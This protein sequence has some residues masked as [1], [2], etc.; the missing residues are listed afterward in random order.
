MRGEVLLF[1]TLGRAC[2]ITLAW[3][4]RSCT[5]SGCRP[6]S[7]N[8]PRGCGEKAL[9][10]RMPIPSIGLPCKCKGK[11]VSIAACVK[12][13]GSSPQVRGEAHSSRCRCGWYVIIPAGAGRSLQSDRGAVR[14]RDHPRVCGEKSP[15][16]PFP[17]WRVRSPPRMRGEVIL[18]KNSHAAIGITPACAGRRPQR[19]DALT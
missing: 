16:G 17:R 9:K 4:G 6:R 11:A 12:E 1:P 19:G 10:L 8:H 14:R 18:R 5:P 7:W 15:T 3:A 2:G 13:L